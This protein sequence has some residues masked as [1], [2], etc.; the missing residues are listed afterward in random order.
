[1]TMPKP[2]QARLRADRVLE[3]ARAL[4]AEPDNMEKR[5]AYVRATFNVDWT[6]AAI[7][8]LA[9]QALTPVAG[10]GEPEFDSRE[11]WRAAYMRVQAR[12]AAAPQPPSSPPPKPNADPRGYDIEN[13]LR[14]FVDVVKELLT[15]NPKL[16]Q[17]VQRPLR[18]RI[19]CAVEAV[20]QENPLASPPPR[21]EE[22]ATAVEAVIQDFDRAIKDAGWK[23]CADL[24]PSVMDLRAAL[25]PP[26]KKGGAG[27]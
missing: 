18:R 13:A 1:M 25:S 17:H 23:T 7:V 26:T 15:A 24:R 14:D 9:D 4:V 2:E 12:L 3:A 6:A 22:V 11:F 20:N 21:G 16:P 10:V 27:E 19:E 8:A 5:Q